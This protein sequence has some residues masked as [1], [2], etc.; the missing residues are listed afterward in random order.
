[1]YASATWKVKPGHESE[2]TRLWQEN[3]DRVALDNP[4]VTFRLLR[5]TE[6]ASHFVSITGPWRGAEHFGRVRD[7]TE[8]QDWL[9]AIEETL[10]SGEIASYDLVLEI[11]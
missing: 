5:N 10:E 6:S 1:V 2:F 8:F 3:A 9:G 4:G 7:S 11:S